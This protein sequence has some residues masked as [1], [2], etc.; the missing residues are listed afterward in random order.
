MKFFHL[1]DLHIGLKLINRDLGEDQRYILKQITEAAEREKPDA[2]VIAG[3]IYDKAVPSGE[4]VELFDDFITDLTA[5]LPEG[6]IMVISGNHDSASRLDCFRKVLSGQG[7]HMIGMPP[8][9]EDEHIEKVTLQD[10]YGRVNFY[11]LP[12]VKPS[13]VRAVAGTEENGGSLSYDAAVRRLLER[14]A[15]D[16][17]QRNVLV[18]HQFYLPAGKKAEETER[19]DSEIRTVGDIDQVCADVLEPFDYGALGH[20]HKPQQVG[21]HPIWYAGSPLKYSF[22]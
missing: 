9:T 8:R 6:T 22:G 4:A 2:V 10:E 20:I 19:M 13:M 7:L 17:S 14:E 11:L 5:A 16:E 3:D 18:S 1:S 12:F 15:V 21:G